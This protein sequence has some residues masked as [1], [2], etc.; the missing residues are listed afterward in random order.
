MELQ[1][2]NPGSTIKID[3]YP[4]PSLAFTTRTFRRIY[5]CLQALKLGFQGGLRDLL[6]VNGIFM[7]GPYPRQVLTVV[8]EEM[9]QPT[10]L[11]K[12]YVTVTCEKCHNKGNNLRTCKGQVSWSII[13]S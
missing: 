4:E 11:S 1:N 9:N 2:S 12:K 8:G 3:M 13:S 7:K 5:E 10:K 6:G